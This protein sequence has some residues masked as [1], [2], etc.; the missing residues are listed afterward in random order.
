MKIF[1]RVYYSAIAVAHLCKNLFMSISDYVKARMILGNR[2]GIIHFPAKVERGSVL[3]GRNAI[4]ANSY[5][6]GEMGFGSYIGEKCWVSADIGRFSCI[7]NNVQ[8]LSGTHP[9]KEPF[10]S[11][12]PLFYSTQKQVGFSFARE[13]VFEE[14]RYYDRQRKIRAKIGNDCWIGENVLM[15]GGIVVGDGAVVLAGAI[16]TKDIPP[17]A[18]AGGVPAKVMGYRYDEETIDFL[19]STKW[20]NKDFQWFAENH[21]LLCCLDALKE[22]LRTNT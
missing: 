21:D 6:Y 3:E 8:T 1:R 22:S 4:G 11:V 16:V 12:S 19:L 10:A 20:W 17:Y 14:M 13:Q 2:G 5:Y 7:A 18:I 15:T 9:Y